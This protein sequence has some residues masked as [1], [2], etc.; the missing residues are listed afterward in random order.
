MI[1]TFSV[2]KAVKSNNIILLHPSNIDAIVVTD[3][4]SKLL[5]SID[6]NAEQL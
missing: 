2:L 5:K 1:L 6:V 4:V 3:D